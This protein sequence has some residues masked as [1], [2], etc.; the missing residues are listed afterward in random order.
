MVAAGVAAGLALAAPAAGAQQLVTAT[1]AGG[2]ERL[3]T[4]DASRPGEIRNAKIDGLERGDHVA[5]LDVRPCT[6]QLYALGNDGDTSRLYTI[7][8]A[9]KGNRAVATPLGARFDTA[10]TS[11][12]FDFNPAVDRIRIVSDADE[13]L[14]VSPG[15]GGEACGA[16]APA[17]G[18]VAAVDGPLAYAAG[19]AG[20]GTAPD[21]TA[22]A[23]TNSAVGPRPTTTTLFDLDVRRDV[24]VTQ[25]PPNAGTL[26][27][28]GPLGLDAA[29]PTGFDIASGSGGEQT[30]FAALT[31]RAGGRSGLFRIDLATGA[32]TSL[33]AIGGPKGTRG[34]AVLPAGA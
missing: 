10:G 25:T 24:L 26:N 15:P 9:A 7:A 31:A 8:F 30:A 27:T 33:G 3:V 18:T 6:G 17:A 32:A 23:Y 11:F 14:R 5:G 2:K 19:D 16:P 13:N 22:A 20:A 1:S 21:V 4:F 29:L 28:V 34:L 12:G